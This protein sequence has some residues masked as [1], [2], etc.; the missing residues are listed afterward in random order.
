MTYF[1]LN[2]QWRMKRTDGNE[3]TNATVP[4]SMYNDM[5]KA[6]KLEDP[7]YRD[8]E[9][10]AA[11]LSYHDYEYTRNFSAGEE[12]LGCD[13]VFLCCDGLDTIAEIFINGVKAYETFNMHIGYEFD[14]KQLLKK[15]KIISQSYSDH[16]RII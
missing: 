3:W 15:G 7:F 6:G 9:I 4:G 11:K 14:I 12:L 13:K 1:N 10:N 2:G 5:L 16:Q 8:N